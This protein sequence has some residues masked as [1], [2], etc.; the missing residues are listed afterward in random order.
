[1]SKTFQDFTQKYALSKTL[2]FELKPVGETRNHLLTNDIL[3]KDEKIKK[4]YELLKW[5]MDS[6]HEKFIN[7]S[8][9]SSQAK[10]INFSD[11]IWYYKDIKQWGNDKKD[12]DA[13][14]KKMN[15]KLRWEIGMCFEKVAEDWK[16]KIG[17]DILKDKWYKILTEVWVLKFIEIHIDEFV[18][19]SR[20]KE[21][22]QDAL[23]EFGRFFTYFTGYNQNRE[24]YY[25]TKTEKKT[26]IA[27]RI[28]HENLPKFSD[29]IISFE[30]RKDQY[31]E[32][33]TVLGNKK[34]QVKDANSWLMIDT[35]PITEE[36][37][38]YFHFNNCLSQEGIEEYNRVIGHYNS[39]IN[40]YNQEQT[41]KTEKLSGFKTLYKQ[42]G[43]GKWS[44][45]FFQITHDYEKDTLLRK[46]SNPD[47]ISVEEIIDSVKNAGIK[48]F[49][50]QG[51]DETKIDTVR[52]F[53]SDLEKRTDWTGY[54]W[55]KAAFNTISS[56]YFSDW[57]K[58][59]DIFVTLKVFEKTDK[60]KEQETG[61]KAKIPDAIGL[62]KIFTAL[63]NEVTNW[64]EGF[65]RE[66][67]LEKKW[68]SDE[69]NKI[70]AEKQGIFQNAKS[71]SE[72]IIKLLC[73][74]IRREIESWENEMKSV[75]SLTEYHSEESK[76]II[77]TWMDHGV[78]IFRMIKY[79]SVPEAK[80]KDEIMDATLAETLKTLLMPEDA[81]WYGWYDGLRNYLT[82]KVWEDEKENKLKLNFENSTLAAGW[83]INKESSNTCI[84][85]Q[86]SLWKMYLAVLKKNENT[87]F[88]KEIWSRK[89]KIQNPLYQSIGNWW[90]KMTYKLLPGPN[91][92][93]PKCL[94]PTKDPK[95]FWASD[96]ILGI[97]KKGSF[98]KSESS[99]DIAD[100]YK[101]IDFYK[102]ALLKYED[103]KVFDFK[104]RPT[105]EYQDISQFYSDVEIQ[106]YKLSFQDINNTYLDE[107]VHSWKIYLFEIKNQDSNDWKWENHKNNLHTIYWNSIFQD[108]INRPKLNGEAEIFYRRPVD[109]KSLKRKIIKGKEV[110]ENF[111][112]SK[113]KFLFHVPIT[114]NFCLKDERINDSVSADISQNSSFN[115][116]GIDRGEKH[117]VYYSLIDSSGKILQQGSFN[118][119]NGQNYAEKLEKVAGQRD[120]A[121]KNWKK[122]GTIKEL[123]EW[124]ISQIVHEITELAI[125]NNAFII[126][127]D[128]NTGFKRGRQKIE[129]SI[130]QKFEL[131]LAKKLNFVVDKTK[132]VWQIGSVTNAFQLTPPVSNYG[133]I[134]ARKQVGIMFYTRANYTSQT[135]P[136]SGWRRSLYLKY[137][138]KNPLQT[139]ISNFQSIERENGRYVFI[140]QPDLK[141][142]TSW[143]LSSQVDRYYGKKNSHG[144][145][146]TM[147]L[148]CT[149]TLDAIFGNIQWDS[150]LEQISESNLEKVFD[151][152]TAVE[153]LIYVINM[154]MQIRNG[155]GK[156]GINNDFLHSPVIARINGNWVEENFIQF[157]SRTFLNQ[158]EGKEAIPNS[159][160][161]PVS[162]DANGAYNIA[163]KWIIMSEHIRANE[164]TKDID[165]FISDE[166]WDLWLV[167][168][169]KWKEMLP[170]F[171]SRK[172]MEKY[173]SEKN[174][175]S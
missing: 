52:E 151:K 128:L 86:D 84:L 43:C 75:L 108:I 127:E 95:R 152:K 16:S 110:I 106:G 139:I 39:L 37:F 114:L 10:Q 97:Y 82:K 93:L 111:R 79:F 140:T 61:E 29:N 8:L 9:N 100:L 123:K 155:D 22:I 70:D 115:F 65:F 25:E 163:R 121:R 53:I 48:Y 157:D 129:K 63:D 14:L 3:I 117:L 44:A 137:D 83:D 23:K 20:K 47:A 58:L 60:R 105:N 76:E 46:E 131:A 146:E 30:K 41:V 38:E 122:I 145:W 35:Y 103:W 77:K 171:S 26:A 94:I 153:W 89:E 28:I 90:K 102:E 96:L 24:N 165:L 136:V 99:F 104:F 138:S 45:L 168:K 156:E 158:I 69:S 67:I 169:K 64:E 167:D 159:I 62:K 175:K 154:I 4:A 21:D 36:Y 13:E 148:D 149:K 132:E 150:L 31:L 17:K 118:E 68:W 170:I 49:A 51:Q 120:E 42:I 109:E 34:K 40:L 119:I 91:K 85:L 19:E 87:I 160:I 55:S 81:N 173:R 161:S 72:V 134:E 66:R 2:R 80:I 56:W 33:Y 125:K 147:K 15:D 98:K 54:Y 101:I 112:Y 174:K 78:S 57:Q 142:N 162:W 144:D 27:T 18:S 166:E 71:P 74:D 113:E 92:M 12:I 143:K 5:I 130:Y 172:A 7:D 6:I 141:S 124:Y 11:I 164:D 88:E 133:D 107:L 73:L 126:L 50:S 1:M 116:L 59:A 135:D 32:V